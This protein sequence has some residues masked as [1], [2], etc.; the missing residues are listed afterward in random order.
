MLSG[1]NWKVY[2][3]LREMIIWRWSLI[4]GWLLKDYEY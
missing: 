4:L 3:V 1:E 2:V